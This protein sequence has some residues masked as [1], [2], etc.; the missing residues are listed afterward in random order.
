MGDFGQIM[1]PNICADNGPLLIFANDP[2]NEESGI[3]FDIGGSYTALS[4]IFRLISQLTKMLIAL[5]KQTA[6][7]A[8]ITGSKS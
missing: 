6:A 3:V 4:K 8:D 2:F 5:R 1:L 7:R